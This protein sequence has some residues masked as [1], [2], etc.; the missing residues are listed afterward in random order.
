MSHFVFV[1]EGFVMLCFEYL[2]PNLDL[3]IRAERIFAPLTCVDDESS[4]R[5]WILFGIPVSLEFIHRDG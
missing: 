5:T 2:L 4:A 3:A 1:K